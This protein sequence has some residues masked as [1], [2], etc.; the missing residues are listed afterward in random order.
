MI[1][2]NSFNELIKYKPTTIDYF[3]YDGGPTIVSAKI[4]GKLTTINYPFKGYMDKADL[5]IKDNILVSK[6]QLDKDELDELEQYTLSIGERDLCENLPKFE[7]LEE[8]KFGSMWY[9]LLNLPKSLKK[10]YAGHTLFNNDILEKNIEIYCD[11]CC[12]LTS[13]IFQI[14]TIEDKK[15]RWKD[16]EDC[17]YCVCEKYKQCKN[18]GSDDFNICNMINSYITKNYNNVSPGQIH[19]YKTSE[20]EYI[21]K[22]YLNDNITFEDIVNS[23]INCIR[24]I[25]GVKGGMIT[26][27]DLTPSKI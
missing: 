11:K 6:N 27:Y 5:F 22:N 4:D 25:D 20:K 26:Y 12:H 23:K 10:F 18:C 17:I 9:M 15:K 2:I 13:G 7:N 1:S 8:L 24:C 21:Y 14:K 19:K 3:E 16:T